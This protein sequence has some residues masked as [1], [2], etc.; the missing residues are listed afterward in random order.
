MRGGLETLTA[1][2]PP[3]RPYQE[4]VNEHLSRGESVLLVAPTG[5]GKTRAAL[6]PF[7]D[8]LRR[9]LQLSVGGRPLQ[10]DPAADPL[11]R[12]SVR[13]L[14]VLPMR[15]L[16]GTVAA[17][18]NELARSVL[19][20]SIGGMTIHHGGQPDSRVFAENAVA[21]TIDQY[22]TAFAGAPLSFADAAGHAA[23][24]ATLASYSVFD[25]VHLLE[26][27][28][29]LSLLAA[30]LMQRR[31]WRLPSLVMTATLPSSV[32]DY[33]MKY[34]GLTLVQPSAEEIRAQ[35]D[36]RRQVQ[37]CWEGQ[38]TTEAVMERAIELYKAHG[39][40]IWFVN[41]VPDAQATYL[42]LRDRGI[43]C[44][45]L[46]SRYRHEDRRRHE[47]RFLQAFGPFATDHAWQGV[48]VTTQVSEAGL[49]VS[50]PVV[51]TELAPADALVQRA[52]RC[53]RT[54]PGAQGPLRG[55]IHVYRPGGVDTSWLP[56][57][58]EPTAQTE[59]VLPDF[60]GRILDW[61][62]E[63]RLVESALGELYAWYVRGERRARGGATAAEFPGYTPADTLGAFEKAYLQRNPR[64]VEEILREL[65]QVRIS[66]DE[67]AS[68]R[69]K[70]DQ[71]WTRGKP[72]RPW[73]ETLTIPYTT[74]VGR[75]RQFTKPLHEVARS[76]GQPPEVKPASSIRPQ[77]HYLVHPEDAGYDP[78]L[79]LTWNGSVG[80]G[81]TGWFQP[82]GNAAST[83]DPPPQCFSDHAEGVMSRAE[84]LWALMEPFVRG[85]L[86]GVF[87][88]RVD[89]Q[90]FL[91]DLQQIVRSAALYH[92]V[93]K[94]AHRWQSAVRRHIPPEH[95][96]RDCR[97]VARTSLQKPLGVPHAPAAYPFLTAVW[98][99]GGDPEPLLRFLAAA[100]ARHHYIPPTDAFAL[101]IQ[102][103]LWDGAAETLE[104][105][106][107]EHLGEPWRRRVAQA[108]AT[109]F[110]PA[111][112]GSP[113]I[114]AVD[115]PSPS[116]S[117]YPLYTWLH[118]VI[119]VA[120][121]EDAGGQVIELPWLRC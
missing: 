67:P 11:L 103:A 107:A 55:I 109:V 100:V 51:L 84:E 17:E 121:Q 39:R 27:G 89:A 64:P 49:N 18:F 114:R 69:E 120:D 23:A 59:A 60:D 66:I 37:L 79:G 57:E 80:A 52:G 94:L 22:L 44:M 50:A 88:D 3:L 33:L 56:Y 40:M 8:A 76:R 43:P 31:H 1:A 32:R 111:G 70:L 30:V 10:P 108:A 28:K 93:G 16:A 34:G 12:I 116:D 86:T 25:E 82:D 87:A 78:E 68:F 21:T 42:A 38:L 85:W 61:A 7:V 53:A 2:A 48:V 62:A 14:Y 99:D 83:S 81:R 24:G 72:V 41:R 35:R 6:W 105:L 110:V 119:K 77:G 9:R 91:D 65:A 74:F 5:F 113:A 13:L 63:Q 106:A 26:P 90:A 98:S 75:S 45:L 15:A 101:E 20:P 118:R 104:A 92:D 95:L 19:D 96:P 117:F 73:P 29:G 36:D 46:H 71:A 115:V 4:A 102:D 58:E 97:L 54:L 47:D 112:A